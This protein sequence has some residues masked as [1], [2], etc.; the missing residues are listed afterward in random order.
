MA[1]VLKEAANIKTNVEMMNQLQQNHQFV[2]LPIILN[3]QDVNSE[4]YIMNNRN[5]K[6]S[7]DERVTAL[8]RLDLRNLGHLDIYVAKT[9][10]N[11]EVTF[12]VD[13]DDTQED[14]R[15]NTYQLVNKLI[16]ES[17]N[18][19]GIGIMMKDKEFDVFEDFINSKDNEESKRFT[20]DMRA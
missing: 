17:F 18:V 16:T 8:L 5:S 9:E 3:G 11:V 13:K 19:L 6:T 14:L 2:H 10:N 1:K 15:D 4:L 20:F 12:Y 7:S